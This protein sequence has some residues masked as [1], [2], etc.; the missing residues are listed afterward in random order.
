MQ[1]PNELTY[2][3]SVTIPPAHRIVPKLLTKVLP[4]YPPE[5]ARQ[6]EERDV[7]M[8]VTL[9]EDGSVQKVDV[10]DGDPLLTSAATDAVKQ[11]KY[12][13]LTV[14]GKLVNNFVVAIT[15]H[16]KGKVQ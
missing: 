3:M 5:A 7:V 14:K 15:F 10:I 4:L 6:H 12:R 13:P 8:D 11:W 1:S 9:N 16:R 2:G